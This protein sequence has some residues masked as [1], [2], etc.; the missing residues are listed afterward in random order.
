VWLGKDF[1][2]FSF[3]SVTLERVK[4]A[5]YLVN[6]TTQAENNTAYLKYIDDSLHC[7]AY[8][9]RSNKTTSSSSA[10]FVDTPLIQQPILME[11][12][13]YENLYLP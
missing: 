10:I 6:V 13:E 3:S 11:D 8:K 5:H 2:S 4:H 12:R 7:T 1:V 9:E